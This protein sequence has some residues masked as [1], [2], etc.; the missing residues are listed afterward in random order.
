MQLTEE[1]IQKIKDYLL[2]KPITLAY[3]FGSQ[4]K[5]QT[6]ESSDVDIAV[7]FNDNLD[8]SRK[9]DLRLDLMHGITK[10]TKNKNVDVVPIDQAPLLLKFNILKGKIALVDRNPLNR[11]MMEHGIMSRFFDRRFYLDRHTR[12]SL[13]RIAAQGFNS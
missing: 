7:L 3:L 8:Q 12:L 10:I 5:G 1:Q 13:N 6:K 9:F 4:V 2:T 11:I